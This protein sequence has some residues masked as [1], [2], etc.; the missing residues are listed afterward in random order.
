MILVEKCKKCGKRVLFS[1][2]SLEGL[3]ISCLE[4][5]LSEEEFGE[6]VKSLI[7]GEHE[8]CFIDAAEA[9][10]RSALIG[11]RHL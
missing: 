9:A 8:P 4:K 6:I 7:A 11:G 3:C 10:E 2:L 5:E 1:H